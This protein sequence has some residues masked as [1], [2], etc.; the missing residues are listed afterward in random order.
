ME[1]LL[2]RR[3]FAC[4]VGLEIHTCCT[5]RSITWLAGS[6]VD[7]H[8]GKE[9]SDE[10]QGGLYDIRETQF[11]SFLLVICRGID[12]NKLASHVCIFSNQSFYIGWHTR[13][14]SY[15]MLKLVS[16][17]SNKLNQRFI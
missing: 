5:V 10:D 6:C 14:L 15:S 13:S 4:N 3:I 17:Y 12:H 16:A 1:S 2:K 8:G 11:D 9:C 7:A